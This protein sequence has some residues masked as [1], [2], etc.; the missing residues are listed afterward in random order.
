MAD[1]GS[2]QDRLFIRNGFNHYRR[3]YS[4]AEVRWGLLT[5]AVMASLAGWVAWK[6]KHPVDPDLFT[7]GTAL[8]KG[9]SKSVPGT[10][11]LVPTSAA[12]APGVAPAAV[13]SPVDRGPL[14]RDLAGPGW[15]EDKI[16]RFDAENLYVKIDG[17]A[18]FFKN[19]GFEDLHSVL[20][21]SEKDAAVTVDIEV[22]NLGNAPNAMG[23]YGGERTPS[24]RPE[25]TEGG[26][27]HYDRN[28]LYLARGRY[29]VRVLGSDETPVI[30]DKLHALADVLSAGIKGESLPWAYA[31]F[32]GQMGFDPGKIAYSTENAF[33]LAAGRDVW[34]VHPGDKTDD[35]DLFIVAARTA[36]DAR[37]LAAQFRTGF[38]DI[39][40]AA[41]TVAG[42]PLV[43]DRFLGTLSAA[44]A[45]SRWVVGV[46]GAANAARV[47]TEI[48]RLKA[49][50]E[51]ASPALKAR[52]VPTTSATKRPSD[53]H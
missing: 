53:G 19:F 38:L 52:A 15:R 3:R 13:A 44:A 33:S 23:A 14:P 22:Y 8:L 50:L 48:G 49:A 12:A 32:T 41:G 1:P 2:E 24:I 25:I 28:A 26:L 9:G 36:N 7:D 29:Y 18:D 47:E 16:S 37:K 34:T 27:Y 42:T 20:L 30:V 31:L 6:G 5:L 11:T 45:A 10:N 43:K 51:H 4:L 21:V 35:L 17:R 46:H 40:L 39:G